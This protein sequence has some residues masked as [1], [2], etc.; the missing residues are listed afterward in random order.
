MSAIS[1]TSGSQARRACLADSRAVARH[2]ASDLTARSPRHT[3]TQRDA[4]QG[5][6]RSVPI[7][8]S[9]ETASSARS[10]FGIA[11]TTVTCGAGRSSCSMDSTV[12]TSEL[13]VVL[14]TD[15]G[16]AGAGAVREDDPLPRPDPAYDD[17]VPGLL[18]VEG[19]RHRPRVTEPA[20]VDRK[21]GRV[22]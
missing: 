19:D 12:A 5:T 14:S 9:T 22:T 11:C 13:L 10:P 18:T 8:V 16:R 2:F 20:S 21:T 1:V 6:I 4:A 17:R 15:A 3:A 7:S